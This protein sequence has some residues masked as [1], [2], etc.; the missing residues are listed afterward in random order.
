MTWA[1]GFTVLALAALLHLMDRWM[2]PK[3]GPRFTELMRF[4]GNGKAGRSWADMNSRLSLEQRYRL[5]VPGAPR[6]KG[7]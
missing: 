5:P 7:K 4:P 6:V 2:G 1:I 3:S